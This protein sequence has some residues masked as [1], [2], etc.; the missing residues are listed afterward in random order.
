[1]GERLRLSLFVIPAN[2]GQ[3]LSHVYKALEN[4][5]YTGYELEIVDVEQE[6][7][8]A[9]KHGITNT[10]ALIHHKVQG[11]NTIYWTDSYELQ[12]KLGLRKLW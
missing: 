6:A 4:L 11:N 7:E 10:P 1:M 9:A 5:P 12:Y 3:A 2:S 8:K